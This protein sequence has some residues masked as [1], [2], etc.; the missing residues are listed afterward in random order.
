MSGALTIKTSRDLL[1][2]V[3]REVARLNADTY[4]GD[5][6]LNACVSAYHLHEWVWKEKLRGDVEAQRRCCGQKVTQED[7]RD[8][9]LQKWHEFSLAQ[10]ICNGS[11]HMRRHRDA[12]IEKSYEGGWGRQRWDEG[13]WDAP[14]GFIVVVDGNHV[15]LNEELQKLLSNWDDMFNA[16]KWD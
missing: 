11:K 13:V 2:K 15:G 4:D 8:W 3:R 9:L 12:K 14:A 10:E 5:A 6:A 7:F 16:M 1:E